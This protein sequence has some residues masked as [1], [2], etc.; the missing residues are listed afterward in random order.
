MK[1]RIL[2]LFLAVSGFSADFYVT[3]NGVGNGSQASP[4]NF[5]QACVAGVVPA[6]STVWLKGGT[7]LG[8]FI[9]RMAGNAN[10]RITVRPMPGERAIFD[11]RH[12]TTTPPLGIIW[13]APIFTI[14]TQGGGYVDYVDL[15][16]KWSY[17]QRPPSGS[18]RDR[19]RPTGIDLHAPNCRI[20]N[21]LLY[22]VGNA[23]GVWE[24]AP[25]SLVYGNVVIN[26]GWQ[27]APAGEGSPPGQGG[28]GH[29]VY[30]QSKFGSLTLRHNIQ[31]GG[32]GY[33]FHFYTDGSEVWNITSDGNVSI[34]PGGHSTGWNY[35]PAFFIGGG[36]GVKNA[37]FVHNWAFVPLPAEGFNYQMWWGSKMN[38]NL[39]FDNNV[40]IGSKNGWGIENYGDLKFRH[41]RVYCAQRPTRLANI[42]VAAFDDNDYFGAEYFRFNGAVLTYPQWASSVPDPNGSFSRFSPSGSWVE[43]FANE[44]EVGRANIVVGNFQNFPSVE[45]EIPGLQSG[46]NF[47]LRNV[48]DWFNP[49]S[50]GSYSG[51]LLIPLGN[52]TSSP[53]GESRVIPAQNMVNAFVVRKVGT[54]VV[55]IPIPIPTPTNIPP[56]TVTVTNVVWQT[57]VSTIWQTNVMWQTNSV[58]VGVTN[59]LGFRPD[60]TLYLK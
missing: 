23:I 50:S 38:V 16:I 40:S 52:R 14:D 59:T 1:T 18:M 3:P 27:D 46:D 43:V 37:N 20:I 45:V 32:Y 26:Q 31:R 5:T 36:N 51:K 9:N 12:P 34:E 56:G 58:T 28:T 19:A 35:K 53:I 29:G 33:G 49:V 44:F 41:N 4:A 24:Q 30:G 47:V 22:D 21:C 13:D 10:A 48:A 15:E 55:V 57:N 17:A 60:G 42:Q 11:S 8:P 39:L 54:N 6:G 7:Y 2:A 25:G